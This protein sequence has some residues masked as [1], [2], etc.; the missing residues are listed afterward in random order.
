MSSKLITD[1]LTTVHASK[2]EVLRE[3]AI[4]LLRKLAADGSRKARRAVESLGDVEY[5]KK[6]D[7]K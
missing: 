4:D 1:L 7:K 5:F 2:S 3:N 6:K